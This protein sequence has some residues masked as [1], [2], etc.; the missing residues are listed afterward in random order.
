TDTDHYR[1]PSTATEEILAGIYAQVLGLERVGVDDSF[2]DLGGD[3]ILAMR[4]VA[5]VNTDLD[6]GLAVRTLF[7]APTVA[8][9]APHVGEGS[10]RRAPLA[11]GERPALIPLSFAQNRM[12]FLNRFED[13]AA[14]YNMPIAFRI[15]GAL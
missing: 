7:D 1:A 8:Q 5:A 2:F 12:W 3:S 10:D 4:V 6:A 15:N 9:L 14:T 13:G 11:A